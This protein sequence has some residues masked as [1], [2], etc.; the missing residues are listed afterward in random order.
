MHF[1]FVHNVL[2]EPK[3]QLLNLVARLHCFYT[4]FREVDV[5]WRGRV[6]VC[7]FVFYSYCLIIALPMFA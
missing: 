5:L 2:I 6:F 4:V 3:S 1:T 7:L